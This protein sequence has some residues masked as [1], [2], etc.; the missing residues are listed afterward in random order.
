MIARTATPAPPRRA[1]EALYA[2]GHWLYSQQRLAHALVVFRALIHLA[3][4]DERGWLAVGACHE[5]HGQH[6]IALRLYDSAR[7][8]APAAPRCEIAR[9]R[10]LRARGLEDAARDAIEEAA[11]IAEEMHDE[12][13]QTLVAAER[14]RS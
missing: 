10:I 14:R 7:S 5:A 3:P 2:T 1:V 12:D 11:R 9:S 6:D 4:E 8:V 13:L